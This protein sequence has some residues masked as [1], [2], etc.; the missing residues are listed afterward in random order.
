[1]RRALHERPCE[2]PGAVHA[3]DVVRGERE[4]GE[5]RVRVLAGWPLYLPEVRA[6]D[7]ERRRRSGVPGEVV[8]E[9]TWRFVMSPIK[10]FL[11]RTGRA[12]AVREGSCRKA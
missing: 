7:A 6:P 12:P 3:R 2:L 1:M 10:T 11:V 9:P 8:F 5:E 4:R